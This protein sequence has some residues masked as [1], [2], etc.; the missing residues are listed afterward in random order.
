MLLQ[1]GQ[2]DPN[3]PNAA[4]GQVP[5]HCASHNGDLGAVNALLA[6]SADPMLEDRDGE[7]PLHSAA[8]QGHAIVVSA[9]LRAGASPSAG[10]GSG[11]TA[12]H[13]AS[14]DGRIEC[15]QLLL[16]T[17]RLRGM[18]FALP[19]IKNSDKR[20]ALEEA[21]RC[22]EMG[23]ASLLTGWDEASRLT[24][25]LQRLAF[26]SLSHLRLG[27]ETA[28]EG[29]GLPWSLIRPRQVDPGVDTPLQRRGAKLE[30]HMWVLDHLSKAASGDVVGRATGVAQRRAAAERAATSGSRWGGAGA[31]AAAA[32]ASGEAGGNV[33]LVVGW[34]WRESSVAMETE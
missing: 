30:L 4:Q 24:A 11:D 8:R 18:G 31:R 27:S 1:L 22:R 28:I 33:K 20:N 19:A 21:V 10:A 7:T 26:A 9:L 29:S 14:R 32:T 5:L 3:T 6:H 13:L 12:L 23:A 17:P 15:M 16:C 2:V 34:A 25:S